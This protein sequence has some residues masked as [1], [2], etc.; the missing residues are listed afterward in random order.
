[1]DRAVKEII[2]DMMMTNSTKAGDALD[3]FDIELISC[4]ACANVFIL[5]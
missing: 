3:F 1:M 2:I 4:C 5:L